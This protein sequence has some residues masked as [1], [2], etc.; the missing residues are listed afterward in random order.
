[1]Q[2][3]AIRT[4]PRLDLSVASDQKTMQLLTSALHRLDPLD[5][6]ARF[7]AVLVDGEVELSW[8][9]GSEAVTAGFVIWRGEENEWDS[10]V[11]ATE[12]MLP[13]HGEDGSAYRFVDSTAQPG[14]DYF[15][16]IEEI[17][18]DG[19]RHRHG[20]LQLDLPGGQGD[21]PTPLYLPAI[22]S[23]ERVQGTSVHHFYLPALMVN[24]VCP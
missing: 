9:T 18:E 12:I 5:P 13:A 15:Y 6:L 1:M 21:E 8:Q 10:A 14:Q 3:A 16:W 2:I 22:F 11:R 17:K 19:Y 20:A 7:D 24:A 23:A 4:S